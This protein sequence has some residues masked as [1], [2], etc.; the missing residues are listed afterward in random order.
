MKYCN[1]VKDGEIHLAVEKDGKL[2]DLYPLT[3][4]ELIRGAAPRTPGAEIPDPVFANVVRA[5]KLVCVGLNYKSHADRVGENFVRAE[6]PILFSK[7]GN[8]LVPSGA[9]VELPAWEDSYDY[10]AELVIVI[11]KTAWNIEVSEAA[12]HIFGYTCG[13]K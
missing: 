12:E 2:Y 9:D 11:G 1:V 4:E 8:A 10:E 5:E 7:F 13:T 6:S 3:M